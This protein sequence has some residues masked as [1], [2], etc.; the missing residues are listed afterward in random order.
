MEEPDFP[1]PI[2]K[3][4]SKLKWFI[5]ISFAGIGILG[6]TLIFRKPQKIEAKKIIIT[7]VKY[8]QLS[9]SPT[10]R[11]IKVK[12]NVTI[13]V[14]NGTGTPGQAGVI[15]KTLEAAGYNLDNI[16]SGN[17]ET[18]GETVTTITS[19]ADF[20]E[21]VSDIKDVLKQLYP[22]IANGKSNHNPNEDS[23]F[24]VI[25][26]TGGNSIIT[27]NQNPNSMPIVP[28][29]TPSPIV[30]PTINP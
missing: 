14:L 23:G 3:N 8:R 13:Q 24:D 4:N 27:R 22:D 6:W 21:I 1:Y 26:I 25:I 18:I 12:K 16:K 17:A 15:V 30:S 29:D 10:V 28:S 9:N 5:L 11:P 7:P 19:I 2:Q 20:E